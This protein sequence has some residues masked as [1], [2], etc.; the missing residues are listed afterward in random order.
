MDDPA[1]TE[2]A[3]WDSGNAGDQDRD[4]INAAAGDDLYGI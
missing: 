1:Q 3:Y 4:N 2:V